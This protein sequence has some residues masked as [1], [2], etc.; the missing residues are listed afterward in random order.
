MVH[1][2]LVTYTN[3]KPMDEIPP[4]GDDF[5][6]LP[7]IDGL[8]SVFTYEEAELIDK[9]R[10]VTKT[11]VFFYQVMS[12][13][14]LNE[15]SRNRPDIRATMHLILTI[16]KIVVD[17]LSGPQR[18]MIE[19]GELRELCAPLETVY[20]VEAWFDDQFLARVLARERRG[21]S[22][23]RAQAPP[24]CRASPLPQVAL[25]NPWGDQSVQAAQLPFEP[26]AKAALVTR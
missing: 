18:L 5:T 4:E 7:C 8:V 23:G 22:A 6:G 1:L 12:L 21:I 9:I 11:A 26:A 25:P 13:S 17:D 16:V 19:D 3:T 14:K 24:R 2:H 10:E 15:T 20:Y